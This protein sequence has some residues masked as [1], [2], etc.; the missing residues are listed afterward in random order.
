MPGIELGDSTGA[1]P[2]LT[3]AAEPE[4]MEAQLATAS[5]SSA[6][7]S[8]ATASGSSA[9]ALPN[10]L[11]E[12]A[13]W[14]EYG[15]RKRGQTGPTALEWI[16]ANPNECMILR[17]QELYPGVVVHLGNRRSNS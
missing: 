15:K 13:L 14:T 6:P 11:A 3:A 1:L 9:L 12:L 8:T 4:P 5:G 10:A 17:P 7:A 2:E 16:L